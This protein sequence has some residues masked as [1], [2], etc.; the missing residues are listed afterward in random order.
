M[1]VF[2]QRLEQEYDVTVLAS[3][4]TV[5]Y[6]IITQKGEELT[7]SNPSELPDYA[8]RYFEPTVTGSKCLFLLFVCWLFICCVC[9]RYVCLFVSLSCFS[10]N[11]HMSVLFQHSNH[12]TVRIFK[13]NNKIV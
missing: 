6:N 10:I 7:I 9:F 11:S 1:E 2:M 13:G 8:V 4:P 5:P 12:N 3:S